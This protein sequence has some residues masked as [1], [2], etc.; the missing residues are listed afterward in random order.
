MMEQSWMGTA[1]EMLSVQGWIA[2]LERQEDNLL[3][4]S[5]SWLQG[6]GHTDP[7][8]MKVVKHEQLSANNHR[9]LLRCKGYRGA[10]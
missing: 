3:N 7:R 10:W 1:C 4:A 5:W 6:E 2:Q 8:G 9:T